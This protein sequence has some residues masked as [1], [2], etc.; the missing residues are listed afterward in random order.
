M[1]RSFTWCGSFDSAN[2]RTNDGLRFHQ[3]EITG[4]GDLVRLKQ[5]YDYYT[6]HYGL[7]HFR[8]GVWL[9]RLNPRKDEYNWEWLDGLADIVRQRR[10]SVGLGICHYEWPYWLTKR[11]VLEGAATDVM[12]DIA[13]RIA[14]RYGHTFEWY[15][16]VIENGY[17]TAMM[18]TH[19]KWWPSGKDRVARH[20]GVNYRWWE[21]YY[22]LVSPLMIG[23]AKAI[24][25]VDSSLKIASSDPWV[26]DGIL[27]LNDMAR[28]FH[29]MLG[30]DDLVAEEILGVKNFGGRWDL[31][32]IVGLNWY[33]GA[34]PAQGWP[35]SR[36]LVK[37][38]EFFPD[39]QIYLMETGNCHFPK[40]F[41]QYAWIDMVNEEIELAN[42][43]G[44]QVT[45][46]YWAPLWPIGEF[47]GGDIAP[48]ELCYAHDT[49]RDVARDLM[50]N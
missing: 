36:L 39:K 34:G 41:S 45:R 1:H 28:P 31:L 37:A 49:S 40:D 18:S 32:D 42:E 16:P 21:M 20:N 11:Q 24:K 35:L 6:Q 7:R 48:G 15:I 23:M 27:T 10:L 14:D 25:A 13:S 43:Q 2:I 4:H 44:A 38:R 30:V 5:Q 47:H 46:A 22:H 19:R 9:E 3:H 33:N 12:I 50:H 26:N 8:E 29:T 17:W